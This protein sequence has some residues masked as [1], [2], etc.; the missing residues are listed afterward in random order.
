[1]SA[2]EEALG[3]PTDG[4]VEKSAPTEINL[5]E[6]F[7]NIPPG[8][9][10]LIIN[11]G[12]FM[13]SGPAMSGA[14]V[15]PTG[16]RYSIRP[17]DLDLYCA[18]PIKC[19][20]I[21]SFEKDKAQE[22]IQ[23]GIVCPVHVQFRCRNCL[24]A[25]KVYSLLVRRMV[26][27]CWMRK[28]GELPEFGPPTPARVITVIGPERDY[29]LKGRRCEN[30]GLGIGAFGYYRRV[31]ENQKNRIIDEIIRAAR[32]VNA[33]QEMLDKLDA[34]KAETQFT[35]AIDTIKPVFQRRF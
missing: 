19:E 35:K 27:H 29:Y 23:N 33:P 13:Q 2:I 3:I 4:A 32:K 15:A 10:E 7:E 1:M 11:D 21:R 18:T 16:A 14:R 26:S 6:F 31:V 12:L 8:R 5:K 25:T 22:G 17:V 28:V 34:A 30:Q 24:L 20:G 9:K